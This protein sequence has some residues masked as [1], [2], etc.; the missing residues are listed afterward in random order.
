METAL[1]RRGF[2]PEADPLI[3]FDP[4]SELARLDAL[5][6]DLPHLLQDRGFRA[7][8]RR[9]TIPALP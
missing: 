8:A 6:H 7:S 3:R 1:G 2:L 5:G 4:D 9:L